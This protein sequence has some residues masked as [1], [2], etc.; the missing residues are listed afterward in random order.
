M[1]EQDEPLRHPHAPGEL[2]KVP[3]PVLH[4]AGSDHTGIPGPFDK[5]I[6]QDHVLYVNA[7]QRN[8]SKNHDLTGERQHYI[9]Y[10]HDQ[11]FRNA[12]KIPG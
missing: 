2:D 4:N 7:Q 6:C 9:H 5:Y 3:V 8:Y 12:T 1:A 11:F 10:T